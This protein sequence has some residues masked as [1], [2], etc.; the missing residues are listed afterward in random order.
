MPTNETPPP[1][2]GFDFDEHFAALETELAKIIEKLKDDLSKLRTSR[3]DPSQF[4]GMTVSLDKA[5][6]ESSLLR[7][8][9]HVV[10]KGRNISVGVYEA[11]V[12]PLNF[13]T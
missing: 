13:H 11:T 5:T 4:E 3:T 6:N 9:A 10:V 7:D 12:F 1:T 2:K 8:I